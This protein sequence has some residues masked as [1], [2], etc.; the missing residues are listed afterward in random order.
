MP[1]VSND[2][3]YLQ[4][5]YDEEIPLIQR[6]TTIIRKGEPFQR[7]VLLSKLN[8]IQTSTNFKTLME[9]IL[10]DIQTWDKETIKLFPKYIYPL[11]YHEICR[12]CLKN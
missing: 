11:L 2:E 9:H 12:Y 4:Y 6:L 3:D 7:Q 5:L 1:E 10:N 8:L